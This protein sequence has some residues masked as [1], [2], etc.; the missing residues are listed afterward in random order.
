VSVGTIIV[1]AEVASVDDVKIIDGK[2]Q[3]RRTVSDG[4]PLQRPLL[5][6]LTAQS[7]SQAKHDVAKPLIS[8]VSI[9]S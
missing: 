4:N 8:P 9:T 1:Q 5:P 6:C 2:E 7:L 3:V